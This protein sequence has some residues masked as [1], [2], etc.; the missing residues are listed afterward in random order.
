MQNQ[1]AKNPSLGK[2]LIIK[3]FK[4]LKSGQGI[5]DDIIPATTPSRAKDDAEATTPVIK[6]A[7]LKRGRPE[8]DRQ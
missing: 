1:I 4:A 7:C 5:P 6:S 2:N 8:S 3:V